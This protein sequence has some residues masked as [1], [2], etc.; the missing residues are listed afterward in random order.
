MSSSGM[1]E[2]TQVSKVPGHCRGAWGVGGLGGG[3]VS[4]VCRVV[5]GFGGRVM[6]DV[7]CGVGEGVIRLA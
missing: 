3:L 7:G 5:G 6:G 2:S 1:Q 4:L